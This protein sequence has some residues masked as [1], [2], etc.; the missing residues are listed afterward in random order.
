VGVVVEL[1]RPGRN[2]RLWLIDPRPE[3]ERAALIRQVH[4]LRCGLHMQIREVQ[5]HLEE[6]GARVSRGTVW[7]WL[8]WY[9][10][11]LCADP[12]RNVT[13][14]TIVDGAGG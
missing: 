10:C 4:L 13:Q 3:A 2:G 7:N 14:I 8:A 1:R 11:E 6:N 12:G 5:Q 9:S